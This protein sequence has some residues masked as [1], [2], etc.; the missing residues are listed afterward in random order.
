LTQ[1]LTRLCWPCPIPTAIA[2]VDRDYS[3]KHLSS[4]EKH[5]SD[6]N[7]SFIADNKAALD[8]VKAALG[9]N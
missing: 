8:G 1:E 6:L 9:G 2:E 3:K 7:R 5:T 4:R